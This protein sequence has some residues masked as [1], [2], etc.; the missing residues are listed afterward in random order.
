MGKWQNIC[1]EQLSTLQGNL[2]QPQNQKK[3]IEYFDFLLTI[4]KYN[5][6]NNISIDSKDIAP[7][8]N[9][10]KTNLSTWLDTFSTDLSNPKITDRYT[11]DLSH[12]NQSYRQLMSIIK[13]ISITDKTKFNDHIV[14]CLGKINTDIHNDIENHTTYTYKKQEN[15]TNPAT[16]A[17]ITQYIQAYKAVNGE[18]MDGDFTTTI[19]TT[20]SNLKTLFEEGIKKTSITPENLNMLSKQ[21]SYILQFS[22]EI[23]DTTPHTELLTSL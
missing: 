3:F 21:L 8:E 16:L 1:T 13:R 12:E 6:D 18:K 2:T 4:Q 23:G 22:Q 14:S 15:K 20:I 19:N 17:I 9:I 5:K 7:Y 10:V 11:G